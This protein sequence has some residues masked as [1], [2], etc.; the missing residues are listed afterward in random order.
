MF[1]FSPVILTTNL[2]VL[3]HNSSLNLIKM[4]HFKLVTS[5]TKQPSVLGTRTSSS[6]YDGSPLFMPVSFYVCVEQSL[7]TWTGR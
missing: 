1:P 7:N 5:D 4:G 3:P 6:A 2:L